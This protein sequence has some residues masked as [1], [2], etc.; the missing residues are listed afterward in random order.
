MEFLSEFG[1]FLAK[2]VT[3]VFAIIVVIGVAASSGQRGKKM[4]KRGAIK[5][6]GSMNTMKSFTKHYAKR[7]SIKTA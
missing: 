1:M 7:C 6:Q 2:A 5:S 4:G 3:I